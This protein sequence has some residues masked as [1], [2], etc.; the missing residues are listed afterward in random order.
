MF[1]LVRPNYPGGLRSLHYVR[2]QV[3]VGAHAMARPGSEEITA[4]LIRY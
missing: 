1:D 4:I 3:D 2:S